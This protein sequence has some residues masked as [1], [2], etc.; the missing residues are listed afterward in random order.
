MVFIGYNVFSCCDGGL[1]L[2][3]VKF[4]PFSL[5][6]AHLEEVKY[7]HQVLHLE[8]LDVW[9]HRGIGVGSGIYSVDTCTSYTH[10]NVIYLSFLIVVYISIFG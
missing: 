9:Y 8:P 10:F 6:L 4:V 5:M 3:Q 1:W 2:G 7:Y